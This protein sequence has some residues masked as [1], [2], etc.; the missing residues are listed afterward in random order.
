MIGVMT[1]FDRPSASIDEPLDLYLH[2]YISGRIMNLSRSATTSEA[3]SD[4]EE[5]GLPVTISAS[6]LDGYVLSLT[7]NS[8]SMN[9]RSAVIFGYAQALP[10]TPES[11]PERLFAMEQITN[12]IVPGR[13]QHTRIPPNKGELASTQILKVKVVSGSFKQRRG[14]PHDDKADEEDEKVREST[15]TGV[16][17]V[18]MQ[19]GEQ[20]D[21]GRGEA[22]LP[23]HVKDFV[24]EGNE[25]R[26]VHAVGAT[27]EPK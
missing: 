1:S 4:N 14:G 18:W 15:W 17:P 2:G 10:L 21:G 3:A 6:V 16:L 19:V 7:P 13:Y 5:K 26:R 11:M 24:R 9:Y 20:V 8:H 25:E 27:E 23:Q 22:Q 12:N